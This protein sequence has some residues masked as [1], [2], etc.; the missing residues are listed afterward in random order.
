MYTLTGTEQG[1]GSPLP[2]HFPSITGRSVI[3]G[4]G[5]YFPLLGKHG[6]EGILPDSISTCDSI[7]HPS[8]LLGFAIREWLERIVPAPAPMRT[9][10]MASVCPVVIRSVPSSAQEWTCSFQGCA[11]RTPA[12]KDLSGA[13]RPPGK[14]PLVVCRVQDPL[15]LSPD[16]PLVSASRSGNV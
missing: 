12:P 3:D 2:G 13:E 7:L 11:Q 14:Q 15:S 1:G 8:V 5:Q 6:I 16:A 9:L 4:I 10:E